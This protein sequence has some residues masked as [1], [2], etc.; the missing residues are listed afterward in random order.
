MPAT[1]SVVRRAPPSWTITLFLAACW[2]ASGPLTPD[3]AA[4]VHRVGL[5]AHDGF[6]VWDNSWYGGH[7]LPSYSLIFPALGA[8]FGPRLVGAAAAVASAA[9]FDRLV[10][11][12]HDRRLASWWFAVG[13]IADL[14]I[15][16]LTYAVGLTGGLAAIV[17][18]TRGRPKLAAVLAG[19]CAATSPVAGLFLSLAGVGY[20]IVGRRRDALAMSAV[21][22]AVVVALSMA[23]PEGGNQ[24]FSVGSFA[25]TA[26]I[27]VAAAL[28]VGA[29]RRLYVPLLLYAAAVVA[30]FLVASPMGGNVVRLGTAFVAPAVLLAAGR[31]STGRR[32]ALVAILVAAAAW[33]WIDPFTQAAHG[34]G[35][36]SARPEYY[37][38]LTAALRRAGVASQRVEVPFTR[39][40]WESVHLARR[41]PLAR[42]W[43]R[44]LDR[45]LNPLFY[46]PQLDADAYHRWLRNNAVGYVALPD[47]PMDP[48]GRAEAALVRA[49]QPFLRPIWHDDHWR[50]FRVVDALPLASGP[51]TRVRLGEAS[52]RLTATRP[53]AIVVRVR[54]TPYWHVL[55]GA[56]CV[57]RQGPWTL[58]RAWRP[59]PLEISVRFSVARLFDPVP[60]CP[61]APTAMSTLP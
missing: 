1:G 2:L 56:G 33:Q 24:P 10:A 36:P 52:L 35:D 17:A 32:V 41:F 15:G 45:R 11:P 50:L 30:C 7:P 3:L 25:V 8:T 54:W 57:A 60:A 14:M 46:G 4:Q 16:R 9:L 22:G 27:S 39:D 51:A 38:P 29:D 48:A 28:V 23:F 43:E 5:F 6:T 58:V 59:G 20:A 47:V 26:S 55:S 21:A 12:D 61:A 49:G 37:R 40:H 53:G 44:Q 34:W 18:L 42:G 19:V 13:C 31:A